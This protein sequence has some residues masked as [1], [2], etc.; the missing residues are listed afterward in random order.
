MG[1]IIWG[2]EA[3]DWWQSSSAAYPPRPRPLLWQPR[4][5]PKS[6]WWACNLTGRWSS[7]CQVL[8][9]PHPQ[10]LLVRLCSQ[11]RQS[12]RRGPSATVLQTCLFLHLW[13]LAWGSAQSRHFMYQGREKE[14]MEQLTQSFNSSQRLASPLASLASS[15]SCHRWGQGEWCFC[16]P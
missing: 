12:L 10:H 7:A 9:L 13:K 5:L 15:L 14:V 2:H 8:S 1:S 3:S 16:A 4:T 6:A 11:Y